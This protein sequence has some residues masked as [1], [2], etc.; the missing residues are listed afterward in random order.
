MENY[1]DHHHYRYNAPHRGQKEQLKQIVACPT[2]SYPTLKHWLRHLRLMQPI[3][4][5][6]FNPTLPPAA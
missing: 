3:N 4:N 6:H 2:P 1:S 5:L